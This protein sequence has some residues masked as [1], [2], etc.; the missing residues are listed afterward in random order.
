[1]ARTTRW[2]TPLFAMILWPAAVLG[3]SPSGF[4]VAP[5]GT[6]ANPGTRERPFATLEKARDAVRQLKRQTGLPDGGATIWLRGGEYPRTAPLVLTPEDSGQPGNPLVFA[7]FG[8]EKPVVF[9]GRHITGLRPGADGVWQTALPAAKAGAWVFRTLYVNGARYTLARSPNRGYYRMAGSVADDDAPTSGPDAGKSKWAFRSP[10]GAIDAWPD[11]ASVDLKVWNSWWTAYLT[12]KHFDPATGVVRLAGPARRPLPNSHLSPFIVENHPGALDSPGEW[13]LDRT[14][15]VLR[16]I[17]RPG[18][19]LAK[20]QIYAPVAEQLVVLAGDPGNQRFVEHVVVRGLAFRCNTWTLPPQGYDDVQAAV[21]VG[22]AIEA[23]GARHCLLEDCDVSQTDSYAIWFRAGC[24]DCTVR[25][26]HVHDLGA[27]GVKLG[28]SRKEEPEIAAGANRV[29]NCFIHNGGHVHGSGVG[30]WI[31]A[32]SD[33]AIANNEICDF[34]YTGVSLGWNW[35][36]SLNGTRN[37]RVTH[38]HIHHVMQRLDDGGGIYSLG[39]QPQT[40]LANNHIHD[41]GRDGVRGKGHGI[42]LDEGSASVLV[43][44]NVIRDTQGGAVR[45]QVGTSCNTILN[46]ICALAQRFQIDMEV[47]RTNIFINNI[48]YWDHGKLFRYDKWPNYEKF[49]AKNVYWCTDRQPILFAGHTWEEWRKIR[50]TP[51]GFFKG[52]TMDEGSVIADP[53]FV[54]VGRRDFRLKP[55]SPALARGFQPIDMDAIGLTGDAA[56]R[57][58]PS[59]TRVEIAQE[60]DPG[61]VFSEDFEHLPLGAKPSYAQILEDPAVPG[62]AMAVSDEKAASGSKSLKLVD[63]PGQ[64]VGYTPHF[65]IRPSL[66]SGVRTVAFDL[67]LQPGAQARVEWRDEGSAAGMKV[68]PKLEIDAKRQIRVSNKLLDAAQV[69]EGE[70]LHVEMQCPLGPQPGKTWTL[71][72]TPKQ[73]K[74]LVAEGLPCE[75]GFEKLDWLGVMSSGTV[76]GVWFLDNLSLR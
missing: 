24:R 56:W 25:K 8:D 52:A 6:D 29:E 61:L 69:P 35:G 27:G 57:S 58:L 1:M 43:E 4:Y 28:E 51:T 47:A 46:N 3:A 45:L 7:A 14:G 73:G 49:I 63:L 37:N 30:V 36:T 23:T 44:N 11:L 60:D 13:Q 20:A 71:R 38:N 54:D 31:G 9:G 41:V 50:Q 10:H 64:R 55:T 62:A 22:A 18:D 5:N 39:L 19:D 65:V 21:T 53:Q 67:L 40:V 2:R 42:Y 68:G 16:V 72:L 74:P 59:R 75:D 76:A 17:P 15:G 26:C 12:I 33:N 34:W 70:W 48:V 32:S 66:I